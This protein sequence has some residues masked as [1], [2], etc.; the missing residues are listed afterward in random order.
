M[1]LYNFLSRKK[2]NF[3]PRRAKSVGFYTCGP[4]VYDFAHIGNFRA[5]IFEDI[6]RRT[7][8]YV[9]Y[10]VKQVMN[11]TDI[12][13]KIIRRARA[14]RMPTVDFVKPYEEA[15][16]NDLK[17]LNIKPAW[18]YPRATKHISEMITL[19]SK[20][21]KKGLAYEEGGSIY[22]DISKFERY[23]RLSRLKP[24]ELKSGLRI[25]VDEYTK[26][27]VRDFVLW[28]GK[29]PGEPSWKANFGKGPTLNAVE[30]RPGWHIEC[31]AMSMKY[32]GKSFDIHGGGVDLIFPHHE[33]EIAQS[34]GA[35][36]KPFVRFF[37]EGEH[38]LVDGKKMSKS[39]HNM[40]TLKDIERRG[41]DPLVFRY[42]VLNAH[43][44]SRLNFTW[45][46]L[47]GAKNSLRRIRERMV[48]LGRR[49]QKKT[50]KSFRKELMRRMEDDLD[51][52][53]ALRVFWKHFDALSR[54]D[55]I[56]AS[57]IFGLNLERWRVRAIPAGIKKL[58]KKREEFRGKKEWQKADKIRAQIKK[59]G[60][61]VEDTA[62]GPV[63]KS[64]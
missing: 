23:G 62:K 21:L 7:L 13:D 10:R 46:A 30:G 18:K 58:V 12:D 24:K 4:T 45:K 43:Y 5:Y 34:E 27:N 25:D 29:K 56:W 37:V 42:L 14:H 1:K 51:T 52:P 44:R 41:F 15:F 61:Q 11:I 60:W 20:L 38:L 63:L 49:A 33:N 26:Q 53:G 28:K 59:L 39:L 47:E 17:K 36:G 40:F 35:T 3:R 9:G 16:F 54:D 31:S 22:F 57:Q 6:L 48:I 19:I 50:H 8:E 55:I 32:L 64:A 2:E